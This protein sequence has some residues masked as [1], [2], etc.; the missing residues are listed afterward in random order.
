MV[1]QRFFVKKDRKMQ[2][3]QAL[4]WVDFLLLGIIAVVMPLYGYWS[5]SQLKKD[6]AA[7]RKI[8]LKPFYR[9]TILFLWAPTIV[10][11]AYWLYEG[12]SFSDL[13]LMY[14][15]TV[16]NWIGLAVAVLVAVPL[17]LQVKN[18]QSKKEAAT[19]HV[20]AFEEVPF[21]AA[22]LPKRE[23]DYQ[24]FKLVSVTAA[25]TEEILFRGFLIWG[26]SF[27]M[28]TWMAAG[29][30][31]VA[32]VLGHLYQNN[33]KVLLQVALTG[34]GFTLL[35]LLSGSLLPA[36]LTHG[37]IDLTIGAS[38]WYAVKNTAVTA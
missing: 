2:T 25:V 27:F 18:V 3:I 10:L 19:A 31:L 34:L 26:F 33:G 36:V 37:I 23:D 24:L 11:L 6:V 35:Y 15:G 9:E 8:E 29:L 38:Y 16:A 17:L 30:A 4:T 32:F 28:D 22:I 1:N 12:R 14:A 13:G 21:V 20:S 7:G 5:T